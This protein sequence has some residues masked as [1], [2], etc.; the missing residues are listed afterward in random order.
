MW[1]FWVFLCWLSQVAIVAVVV[2]IRS[3]LWHLLN[4]HNSQVIFFFH[5]KTYSFSNKHIYILTFIYR[6]W[7]THSTIMSNSFTSLFGEQA[8]LYF[9]HYSEWHSQAFDGICF[10]P[11]Y[12]WIR[13]HFFSEWVSKLASGQFGGRVKFKKFRWD[14]WLCYW[15]SI[16]LWKLMLPWPLVSQWSSENKMSETYGVK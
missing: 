11:V 5:F 15:Q 10:Q 1:F 9:F 2:V 8:Y 4:D 12:M 16:T 14:Q 13:K 7:Y 6:F 3:W